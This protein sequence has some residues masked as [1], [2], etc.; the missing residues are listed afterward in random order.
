MNLAR[1]LP[2]LLIITYRPEFRPAWSGLLSVRTL[3]LGRLEPRDV[4]VMIKG[5]CGERKLEAAVV[6]RIVGQTDGIPL[7]VEELTRIAIASA[8]AARGSDV[9]VKSRP[10]AIPPTLQD[11]FMARIDRLGSARE[12]AQIGAVIG[13]EFSYALLS[14]L[15]ALDDCDLAQALERLER[16]ELVFRH[17]EPPEAIYSFSHALVREAAYET[18]PKMKR[19]D[20]HRR[21]AKLL[22]HPST[23]AD[24]TEPEVIARHYT[25]A[26]LVKP[27][28]EWWGKAAERALS[29][30]AYA[31]AIS[32][33]RKALSL[34]Q[35]VVAG[36][37]QH[38]LLLGLQIGYG[39]ALIAARG[40]RRAGNHGR[41]RPRARACKRDRGRQRA[42]RRPLRDVGR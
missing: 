39:Q 24:E 26:G 25:E 13:R 37:E 38:R 35:E 17:G 27:A 3:V 2:I 34:T 22:S 31:E 28:A 7:Y 8:V 42:A 12:V 16:S 21:I 30:S 6:D 9:D 40:P 4:R 14:R 19:Q 18:L 41:L 5:I 20:F 32:N 29:R 15:V 36:P 10:L 1:T 11:S 33:F 23:S